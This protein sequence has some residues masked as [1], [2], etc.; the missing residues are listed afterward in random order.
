MSVKTQP[1][2]KVLALALKLSPVDRV[3][4]IERLMPTLEQA[5]AEDDVDDIDVAADFRQGWKE[6]MTGQVYP[7]DSLWDDADDE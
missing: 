4:L 3:K 2:D 1:L 6:V 5:L 7:I